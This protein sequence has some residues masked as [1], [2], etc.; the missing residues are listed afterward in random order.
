MKRIII[1][2]ILIS[3]FSVKAQDSKGEINETF[4]ITQPKDNVY[5]NIL[6]WIAQSFNDA[7]SQFSMQ[8]LLSPSS[9][10]TDRKKLQPVLY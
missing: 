10:A 9:Q 7:N 6:I 2:L 8:K 5:S 4:K 3:T 1:G